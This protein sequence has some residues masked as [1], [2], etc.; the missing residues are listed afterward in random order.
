MK[1]QKT[2]RTTTSAY[3]PVESIYIPI[4]VT[5]SYKNESVKFYFT[6]AHLRYRLSPVSWMVL[7]YLCENMDDKTNEVRTDSTTT[8][9]F[10][11][12]MKSYGIKKS[13]GLPAYKEDAVKKAYRDLRK[14]NLLITS[15]TRGVNHVNPRH[16][17]LESEVE[18]KK[19]LAKFQKLVDNVHWKKTNLQVAL[20]L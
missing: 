3:K 4:N 10:L 9:N 7:L 13:N 18:R 17:Y 19:Q 1:K 12:A 14:H 8:A 2:I 15:P 16:C 6:F 20:N 5:R 11:K